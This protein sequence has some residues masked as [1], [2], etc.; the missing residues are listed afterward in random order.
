M[1]FLVQKSQLPHIYVLIL[2]M[3]LFFFFFLFKKKKRIKKRRWLT[4]PFG[5]GR[6][7]PIWQEWGLGVA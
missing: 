1:H 2:K 3:P 5:G 4:G 6:S 7:T